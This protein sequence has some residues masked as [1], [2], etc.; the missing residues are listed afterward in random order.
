VADLID[1][2]AGLDAGARAR[3]DRFASAFDRIDA[4]TYMQLSGAAPEDRIRAAQDAAIEVIGNGPRR[5]AVRAVVESFVDAS[6]VAYS[7]R[8]TLTDTLFMNQ[9][10]PDRAEDRVRFLAGVERAVVGLIL[11]EELGD[12]QLAA[13]I[14]PWAPFVENED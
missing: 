1:G 13:L 7:R 5:A 11:W 10:L 6:T 14:G 8:T 4:A 12:D 2:I 9:S 3:L